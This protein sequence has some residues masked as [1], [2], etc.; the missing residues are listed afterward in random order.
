VLAIASPVDK[1]TIVT[2]LKQL[3]NIVATT[4]NGSKDIPVLKKA[5]IGF[6]LC[7]STNEA[8]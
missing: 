2:G 4:G 3:E 1:F 8:I 7:D 6:S 5:D